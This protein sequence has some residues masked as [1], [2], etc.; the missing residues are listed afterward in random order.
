MNALCG[1]PTGGG[2][3]TVTI[4]NN[5]GKGAPPVDPGERR[6]WWGWMRDEAIWQKVRLCQPWPN[7]QPNP[8]Q[9][10]R[11]YRQR[12]GRPPSGDS[13]RPTVYAYSRAEVVELAHWLQERQTEMEMGQ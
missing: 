2:Q 10:A 13:R 1:A 6:T 3:S 4:R 9:I 5:P 7:L 12:F 8:H 11:A